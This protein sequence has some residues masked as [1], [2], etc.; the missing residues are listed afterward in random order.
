M[1]DEPSRRMSEQAAQEHRHKPGD[2]TLAW[3]EVHRVQATD[4]RRSIFMQIGLFANPGNH[5]SITAGLHLV[6]G[7]LQKY[8]LVLCDNTLPV[9]AERWEFRSSGVWCEFVC[10]QPMQHWSY[11]LEAFA[12]GL[13]DRRALLGKGYGHRIPL[14]WELDFLA[15]AE[16][17]VGQNSYHQAG[18]VE[19]VVLDDA[20][21]HDVE[22]MVAT[23]QHWWGS[24]AELTVHAAAGAVDTAQPDAVG[25][26]TPVGTLWVVP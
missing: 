18:T 10:E 7:G 11:G 5:S 13:D 8:P 2:P 22:Q 16:A 4:G 24:G 3:Q 20:G 14:G 1:T 9:P 12:L 19:G 15:T 17:D 26:P 6:V 23:R 21:Q 25:M